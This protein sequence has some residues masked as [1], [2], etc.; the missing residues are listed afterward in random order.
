MNLRI[1]VLVVAALVTGIGSASAADAPKAPADVP[2]AVTPGTDAT[3]NGGGSPCSGSLSGAVKAAFTCTVTVTKKDGGL[4]AF[5][6][7]PVGAVKGL[8]SFVPATFTI[9]GPIAV[10]TYAHRDLGAASA[11]A[12][13]SAG[14]KFAAS[15]SLGDRGDIEV[16]VQSMEMTSNKFPLSTVHV[17]AH[18]VPASA[19]DKAEIQVDIQFESTW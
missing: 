11:S 9:K 6:V 8:K 13:T 14:K 19:K 5:Q 12:V 18:L 4:V 2:A 3:T 16:Q 1:P 17:H 10:Q 7:K 15:D